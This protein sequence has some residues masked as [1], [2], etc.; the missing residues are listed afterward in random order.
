MKHQF[1]CSTNQSKRYSFL[2]SQARKQTFFSLID[3]W[4]SE[5]PC[6]Y[7]QSDSHV[8]TFSAYAM[9][10]IDIYV[11]VCVCVCFLCVCVSCVCVCVLVLLLVYVLCVCVCVLVLLLV[12]VCVSLC[13]CVCVWF[14]VLSVFCAIHMY[15]KCL[16]QGQ[17]TKVK[18]RN[19]SKPRSLWNECRLVLWHPLYPNL[20]YNYLCSWESLQS[21]I[22]T[23]LFATKRNICT[24]PQMNRDGHSSRANPNDINPLTRYMWCEPKGIVFWH[25]TA[26]EKSQVLA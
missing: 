7:K 11:C 21:C 9:C 13:Q 12:Y 5:I 20:S 18:G 24:K 14:S 8:H 22:F 1:P 23:H 19:T 4:I 2:T 15:A 6:V 10:L 16:S 25:R 17:V 26:K 3:T